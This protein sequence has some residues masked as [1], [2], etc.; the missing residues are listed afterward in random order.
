MELFFRKNKAREEELKK[1][2][3]AILKFVKIAAAK[4]TEEISSH[5]ESLPQ[6]E[7]EAEVYLEQNNNEGVIERNGL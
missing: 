3:G 5:S 1:N 4:E 2:K 7:T 6:I